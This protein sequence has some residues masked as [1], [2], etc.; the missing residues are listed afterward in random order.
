MTLENTENTIRGC[1][2]EPYREGWAG[3]H[4]EHHYIIQRL[5]D[6]MIPMVLENN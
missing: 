4:L 3:P 6:Y 5:F 1:L 2:H